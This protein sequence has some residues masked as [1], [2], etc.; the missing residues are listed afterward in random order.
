MPKFELKSNQYIPFKG[1]KLPSGIPACET[2][3]YFVNE[4]GKTVDFK[5]LKP[6]R[7]K[8]MNRY[9]MHS[10]VQA[11]AYFETINKEYL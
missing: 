4:Q 5:T 9:A 2:Y 3:Y 1:K 6:Y 10:E 8:Q 7:G 11:K